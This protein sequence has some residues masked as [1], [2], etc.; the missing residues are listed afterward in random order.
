MLT[1]IIDILLEDPNRDD[2]SGIVA[3]LDAYNDAHSG[4]VDLPGF[5]IVLRD[6]ETKVATGGLY[7]TDGYGWGFIRYLAVPDEYRG[8]GLGRRLVEEAEKIARQRGYVGLWL[9]TFEFQARPF[10]EKLGFEVFGE[11]EGGDGAIARY[12]LKKRF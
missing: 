6:P 12:F 7:A 9:D 11:L 4:M 1:P 10:Y 8:Q 2:L 3:P 5:A